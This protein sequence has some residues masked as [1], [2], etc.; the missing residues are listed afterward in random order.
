[1]F[2]ASMFNCLIF[3]YFSSPFSSPSSSSIYFLINSICFNSM[4]SKSIYLH[5]LI[6]LLQFWAATTSW[7]CPNC[8]IR[9]QMAWQL[10]LDGNLSTSSVSK[11]CN[12]IY[13]EICFSM[14][15]LFFYQY[16]QKT[17]NIT[18]QT[19]SKLAFTTFNAIDFV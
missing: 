9:L 6:Y 8:F 15:L 16:K 17:K 5:I 3:S 1:M 13:L 19:K 2:S 7:T 4:F 14:F 10:E 18:Q 11:L 12:F